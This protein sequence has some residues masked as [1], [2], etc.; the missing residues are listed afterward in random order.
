MLANIFRLALSDCN[1][2]WFLVKRSEKQDYPSP[3][4]LLDW[5]RVEVKDVTRGAVLRV[6]EAT[7]LV[8]AYAQG[9]IEADE[10]TKRWHS[11]N[12]RW[13]DAIYGVASSEGKT[14]QEIYAEMDA[15]KEEERRFTAEVRRSQAEKGKGGRPR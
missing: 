8:T 4:D 10:A 5:L 3:N 2:D 6:S 1:G 11:Y 15:T 7:D 13:G 14:D 12:H 9:K